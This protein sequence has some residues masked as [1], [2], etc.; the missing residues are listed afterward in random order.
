MSRVGNKPIPI[1]SNVKLTVQ[2]STI[3]VSGPKGELEHQV[4]YPITVRQEDDSLVVERPSDLRK[5]RELHGLTRALLANNVNGVSQGFIR[6]LEVNGVGYRAEAKGQKLTMQLGFSHPIEYELPKEVSAK[7]DGNTIALE[8][9]N[10]YI[11]GEAAA[12]I[13]SFRP[14]EPYK[15]KGVRYVGEYVR[16]KVGKKNV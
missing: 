4:P 13:R 12:K 7:V 2:G 5:H 9:C 6:K 1:P 15:G 16:R 10:K 3:S 8:S 11:L 14:P